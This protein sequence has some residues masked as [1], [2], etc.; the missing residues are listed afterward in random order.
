MPGFAPVA[1]GGWPDEIP[2]TRDGYADYLATQSNLLSV[3]AA[4]ARAWLRAEL[5]PFFPAGWRAVT[6][7]ASYR[8]LRARPGE[9][10][11]SRGPGAGPLPRVTACRGDHDG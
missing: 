1:A 5:V 8:V 7:R 9:P 6:F 2:F 3:P 10:G 11:A 4:E